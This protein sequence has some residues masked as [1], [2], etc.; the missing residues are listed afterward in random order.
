MLQNRICHNG[1]VTY[2]GCTQIHFAVL[3]EIEFALELR[4]AHHCQLDRATIG[5]QQFVAHSIHIDTSNLLAVNLAD[6]LA[7][8]YL[9]TLGRGLRIDACHTQIDQI[10]INRHK[11]YCCNTERGVKGRNTCT[12]L[13]ATSGCRG[14]YTRY[15]RIEIPCTINT[16]AIKFITFERNQSIGKEVIVVASIIGIGVFQ[17]CIPQISLF[18]HLEHPF[19]GISVGVI[20][21]AGN[22]SVT[23]L[24]DIEFLFDIT[25][26][27]GNN[28]LSGLLRSVLHNKQG[29][30]CRAYKIGGIGCH[31]QPMCIVLGLPTKAGD[32][33]GYFRRATTLPADIDS[34]FR[35]RH[36]RGT[37]VVAIID[38]L[39][40][41]DHSA[42]H[43]QYDKQIIDYF[44]HTFSPFEELQRY[45]KKTYYSP[46]LVQIPKNHP[47]GAPFSGRLLRHHSAIPHSPHFGFRAVQTYR[48]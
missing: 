6:I 8:L 1:V 16:T 39:L 11:A 21:V 14:G 31:A 29:H 24:F 19:I 37:V 5:I 34:R 20:N 47:L 15:C 46:F 17:Q 35:Q 40:A 28:R 41:T 13:L 43:Q 45:G 18:E 27:E 7:T 4:T 22:L 9:G 42:R 10:L 2:I 25:R 23:H 38:L 26:Q 36:N 12:S 32:G 44:S 33:H 3:A 48:P 30:L